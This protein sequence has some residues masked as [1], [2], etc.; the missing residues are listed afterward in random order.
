M[1][2]RVSDVFISYARS[3]ASQAEKV[4]EALRSLGYDVW[5]D[6]QL[7]AHRS[8]GEVIEERLAAAT[9]VVVIWSAEAAKSEWVQSEADQA[10]EAR[11][12]VQLTV[13]GARLP[14]P[15]DRIQ[16]ADLT[17]WTGDREA[18]GWRKVVAPVPLVEQIARC[19]PDFARRKARIS[20]VSRAM[21][22]QGSRAPTT[23]AR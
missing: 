10:R 21:L 14:M 20:A 2:A 8:Y 15:F 3:T 6:D 16:C 13:D 23:S 4:A 17:G 18:P 1:S 12:L 22:R 11:K 7:P 5:R 9:A 19:G